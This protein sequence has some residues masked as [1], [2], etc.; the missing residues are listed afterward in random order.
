MTLPITE[1]EARLAAEREAD[2]V[3]RFTA[4]QKCPILR[5]AYWKDERKARW[6]ARWAAERAAAEQEK[7]P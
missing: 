4:A 3:V 2:R 5:D 7:K 6:E 1:K